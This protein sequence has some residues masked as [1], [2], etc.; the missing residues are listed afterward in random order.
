MNIALHIDRLV[1]DGL[2]LGPGQ[3]DLVGSAIE[4][5]LTRLVAAG[6]IAPEL[7]TGV[8]MPTLRAGRIEMTGS[9]PQAL[10]G[11]IAQAMYT[12]LGARGQR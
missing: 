2:Q 9:E 8:A 11:Q 12:G 6:G 3:A 7:A 5:E 4:A 1:L 10:G